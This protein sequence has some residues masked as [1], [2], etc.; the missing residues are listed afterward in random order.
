MQHGYHHEFINKLCEFDHDN[1]RDI[2]NRLDKGAR[3]F[4]EAGFLK[5]K[6]F[7]APYDRM[8]RTSY[9]EVAK[10]FN[11]ISTGWF[12]LGRMPYAWWPKYT[13]KK[14]R[15]SFHWKAGRTRLLSHPGCHLSYHRPYDKIL[16]E[17]IASIQRRDLTVLVTHWWEFFRGNKP[18]EKFIQVLHETSDYLAGRSDIKVISFDD[19]VDSNVALN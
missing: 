12:E 11:I 5:P 8:T 17:I 3:Y 16:D 2:A 9:E 4:L 19:V 6:T 10:R 13:L 18:D 15:H 1:R 7:V 14:L